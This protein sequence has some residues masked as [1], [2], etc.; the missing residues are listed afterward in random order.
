VNKEDI[1][2]QA[3]KDAEATPEQEQETKAAENLINAANN[4]NK[5]AATLGDKIKGAKQH[6]SD[7]VE[8]AL[9]SK[10]LSSNE[11]NLLARKAADVQK[12]LSMANKMPQD[13]LIKKLNALRI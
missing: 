11:K 9:K 13:E 4:I 7:T 8:G 6:I 10:D 12:L 1:K 5:N 2:N 3:R